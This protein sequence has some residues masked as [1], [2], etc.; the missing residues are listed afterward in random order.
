[1]IGIIVHASAQI[2]LSI[3]NQFTEDKPTNVYVTG[4]DSNNNWVL[5]Q[6]DGTWYHPNPQS[7]T[8]V[9]ITAGI[10]LPVGKPGTTT[11][12]NLPGYIS[13]GRVWVAAGTLAFYAYENFGVVTLIQPSVIDNPATK[14]DFIEFSNIES[15]GLFVNLSY[16]DF[17]GLTLAISVKSADGSVQTAPGFG[18]AA[19]K[20][21]CSQ[22]QIVETDQ[23][24]DKLCVTDAANDIIRIFSPSTYISLDPSAFQGYYTNYVDNIWTTYNSRPLI[25]DTE[26][27]AGKI[28]CTTAGNILNCE[29]SS[30]NYAKPTAA[31]IFSCSTGPFTIDASDNSI[32]LAVV[33][34]LCAAFQRSTLSLEG[35][36][37]QPNLESTSYY[38]ISPTNYYSK[39]VHSH[40]TDGKGYAFPYDDVKESQS[41]LIYSKEPKELKIT[42]TEC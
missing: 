6:P 1:M 4:V 7:I 25:I 17:V 33:P 30:R 2:S 18:T 20:Q 35:G 5:L 12:F 11:T 31:D 36:N 22:L 29:N 21:I 38:T 24:W 42:V 27:P 13:S 23:P 32:H 28:Q 14:Y 41:G 19:C 39:Y 10:E 37:T 40:E 34:R 26:G 15:D 16:V 8:P 9:P 3:V